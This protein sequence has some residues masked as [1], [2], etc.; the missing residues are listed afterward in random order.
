MKRIM[1]IDDIVNF[2]KEDGY[3]GTS[4]S[5]VRRRRVGGG[6]MHHDEFGDDKIHHATRTVVL[7]I[8]FSSYRSLIANV[9]LHGKIS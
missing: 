9:R 3:D 7:T 4:S 2:Y 1:S 8:V 5:K 6:A